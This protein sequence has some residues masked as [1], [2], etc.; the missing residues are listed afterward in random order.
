MRAQVARTLIDG[1]AAGLA[2]QVGIGVVLAAVDL[3]AGRS[4]LFTPT[5]L[6][7][8]LFEGVRD[9][10]SVTVAPEPL[11]AYF[12]VHV[13]FLMAFGVLASWLVHLSE[14]TPGLW[15]LALLSFVT[16]AWHLTGA[17]LALL[18]EVRGCVSLGWIAVA[19]AAGAVAMAG[20][21]V[22]SHRKLRRELADDRY[23]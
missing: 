10:C 12:A 4:A 13:G 7:T 11:L 22:V 6:G 1:V 5:L 18:G 2:A 14:R 20:Y 16:V 3:A 8:A 15:F 21:L 9:G 17:V 19:S 23:T